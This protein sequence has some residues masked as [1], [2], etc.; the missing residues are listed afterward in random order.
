LIV[1]VP[2]RAG[3][4]VDLLAPLKKH[5]V[6]LTRFESRPAKSSQWE[7]LFYMDL[8]GHEAQMPTYQAL[9]ELR[10]LCAFYQSLG[11]YPM[12]TEPVMSRSS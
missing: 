11:S 5:G 12:A 3:A 6:S 1:S 7:Y 2:N 4:L 8:E 9:S 10:A